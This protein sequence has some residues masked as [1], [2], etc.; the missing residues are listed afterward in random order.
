[1]VGCYLI[2]ICHLH[3]PISLLLSSVLPEHLPHVL[4][5][6]KLAKILVQVLVA[7][8]LSKPMKALVA[9]LRGAKEHSQGLDIG[10]RLS[11]HVGW[12]STASLHLYSTQVVRS[13]QLGSVHSNGLGEHHFCLFSSS[14]SCQ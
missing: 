7:D 13:C 12:S 11:K 6:S 2:S 14:N 5:L 4:H 9:S 3:M 10:F 8:L 1:M